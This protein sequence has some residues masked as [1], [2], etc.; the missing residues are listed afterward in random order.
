MILELIDAR[1]MWWGYE[2]EAIADFFRFLKTLIPDAI[3]YPQYL[4]HHR[5]V[6]PQ[7][8]LGVLAVATTVDGPYFGPVAEDLLRLK[9]QS[10]L[11]HARFAL[12]PDDWVEKMIQAAENLRE[13]TEDPLADVEGWS[14][15]QLLDEIE[16]L[17]KIAVKLSD[18]ESHK[19][20][21]RRN[22]IAR[23]YGGIEV[24]LLLETVFSLPLELELTFNIPAIVRGWGRIQEATGCKPLPEEIRRNSVPPSFPDSPTTVAV[25]RHAVHAAARE[26]LLTT[27]LA[28]QVIIREMQR[29][30]AKEKVPTG[31]LSFDAEHAVALK[32]F[33]I[34]VTHDTWFENTLRAMTGKIEEET[35]G[36]WRPQVATN[37]KQLQDALERVL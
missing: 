12:A 1:R 34:V 26:R 3:E 14:S 19:L 2:I 4:E 20:E 31:G 28:F 21:K 29:A 24:G 22:K 23:A 37:A 13:E 10:Q 7:V 25:I 27:Y 9:A 16:R 30:M 8:W 11:L 17:S 36:Q 15:Q 35:G 18:H 33:D 5:E 32:R 6:A